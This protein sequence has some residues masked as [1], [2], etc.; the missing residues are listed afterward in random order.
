[1]VKPQAITSGAFVYEQRR[2]GRANDDFLHFF[3]AY[4]AFSPFFSATGIN[5]EGIEQLFGLL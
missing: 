4:R 5:F 1:M 2:R 3:Q